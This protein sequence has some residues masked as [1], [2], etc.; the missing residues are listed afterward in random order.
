VALHLA[1]L[2]DCIMV[3]NL[4]TG[5]I[6]LPYGVG[7]RAELE[8]RCTKTGRVPSEWVRLFRLSRI[9]S[10]DCHKPPDLLKNTGA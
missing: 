10:E 6:L 8:C 4:Q 9:K 5:Y 3:G 2:K 1:E 7:L